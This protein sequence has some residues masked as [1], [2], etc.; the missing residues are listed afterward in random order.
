ME[1]W[2]VLGVDTRSTITIKA[3][4]KRISGIK[5]FLQG[6][7]PTDEP[8]RYLGCVVREQFISHDRL[9]RLGV[10]P[11]PGDMVTLYFNRFGDLDKMDVESGSAKK[12]YGSSTG[13]VA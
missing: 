10:E 13:E 2:F 7:A 6:D 3:E 5:L 11:M 9:V 4:G 8:G 1:T 12:P